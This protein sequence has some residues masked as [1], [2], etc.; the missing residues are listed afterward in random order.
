MGDQLCRLEGVGR[1]YKLWVISCVKSWQALEVVGD[2]LCRLEGV[3]RH[4]KLWVISCV[5]SWQALE[6]GRH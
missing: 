2:Q 5:K 4:Y 6:V 1:H 3:G